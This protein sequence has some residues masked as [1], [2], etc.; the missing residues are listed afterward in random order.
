LK[1]LDR[2]LE[3]TEVSFVGSRAKL[4]AQM[5]TALHRIDDVSVP[6][7]L[8]EVLRYLGYPAGVEPN[9]RLQAVL[10]EWVPE[11]SRRAK[12]RAVYRVFPIAQLRPR[13]L[14]LQT[15]SGEVEFHGAVG[16][17]LGPSECVALFIATAGPDVERL[18]SE[19]MQQGDSLESM[20]V[21][22][23]GAERA[24]AAEAIVIEQLRDAAQKY[25]FSPTL[26]YSPGYCG[27]AVT[28]QRALFSLF[29][30]DD[31]GVTLSDSCLMRPL[32]S[33]SGLIGLGPAELTEAIGSPCDRCELYNCGM[34]R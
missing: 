11:A 3:E 16:E 12:P 7:D 1:C 34:R 13:S 10:D 29:G 31:V 26:P 20:I 19:L 24:E 2:G 27:M 33:I 6:V 22:A 14:R 18:A 28:E 32:K 4:L 9:R 17:F 25:A 8:G 15:S 5:G 21:N 23:V 30:N